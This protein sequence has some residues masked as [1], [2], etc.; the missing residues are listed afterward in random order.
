MVNHGALLLDLRR[1]EPIR[2]NA[3]GALYEPGLELL[4]VA[5]DA[6]TFTLLITT[7]ITEEDQ[8]AKN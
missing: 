6:K 1:V 4:E 5:M 7:I 8:V 2:T 3:S